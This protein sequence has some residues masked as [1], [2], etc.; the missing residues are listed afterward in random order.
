MSARKPANRANRPTETPQPTTEPTS[1]PASE[2]P[3]SDA[4][5]QSGDQLGL[6]DTPVVDSESVAEL[7]EEGQSFEA[8]VI[9]GVE[10]APDPDL[11]EV[12]TREVPEDDVP[13]EYLEGDQS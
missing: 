3:L 10:D 8:G 6:P 7:V 11:S 5:G 13:P 9:E 12:K 4:A 2:L 1:E